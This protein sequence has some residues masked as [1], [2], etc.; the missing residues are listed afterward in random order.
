MTRHEVVMPR[1]SDTMEEGAIVSWLRELG[2]AVKIGDELVEIETDKITTTIVAEFGGVLLEIQ[3]GE[4]DSAP[5]GAVLAVVG[6]E[7]DAEEFASGHQPGAA[8]GATWAAEEVDSSRPALSPEALQPSASSPAPDATTRVRATPIARKVAADLGVDLDDVE[9]GSGPGGRILRHDVERSSQGSGNSRRS[10]QD[11]PAISDVAYVLTQIQRVT[12]KRMA[13]SKR[14]IPHFYLSSDVDMTLARRL[15]A[16]DN[17]TQSASTPTI[18]DL[19]VWACGL[20]LRQVPQV[21]AS[22]LG[23]SIMHHG[24][25]NVGV[26]VAL[27]SGDLLVPVVADADRKS[28]DEISS[29]IRSLAQKARQGEIDLVDLEGGTFTVSNLGM[30]GIDEFHAII[31]PPQSGIL[32]VGAIRKRLVLTGEGIEEHEVMRLSLSADHRV[33]SGVTGAMFLREVCLHL[34]ESVRSVLET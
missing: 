19:A 20:A 5:P 31:S 27:D 33:F 9:Q 29:E 7:A 16:A 10:E 34:E 23:D 8:V 28:P 25:V 11:G 22:F 3:F 12:A 6:S 4:G 32:G 18:T 13:E 15:L 21:N 1:L 26:A 24:A 14:E 30:F 2:D 17:Q